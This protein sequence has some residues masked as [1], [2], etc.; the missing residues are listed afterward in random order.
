MW[1]SRVSRRAA[2]QIPPIFGK[3]DELLK[4]IFIGFPVAQCWQSHSSA[5]ADAGRRASRHVT[6]S[7]TPAHR[8]RRPCQ[9]LPCRLLPA[10]RGWTPHA[11]G[12]ASACGDKTSMHGGSLV[13]Y[14]FYLRPFFL[15]LRSKQNTFHGDDTARK[16]VSTPELHMP[17]PLNRVTTKCNRHTPPLSPTRPK[18]PSVPTLPGGCR[19]RAVRPHRRAA[20]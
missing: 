5:G 20:A 6:S 4:W 8:K 14:V 15:L 2:P 12:D 13:L 1:K 18:C 16:R 11:T 10:G 7:T 9:L 19:P 3:T 17:C